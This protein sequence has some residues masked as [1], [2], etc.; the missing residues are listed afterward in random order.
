[1]K[2]IIID[3][4]VM[5]LLR[6]EDTIFR[7]GNISTFPVETAEELLE[8]HGVH[9]G[10]LIIAQESIQVMGGEGLCAS[11]RKDTDLKNVSILIVTDGLEDCA[12]RWHAA[13]ANAVVPKS[14]DRAQL[15][16][17]I[18]ELLVIPERK[19]LRVQLSAS[20]RNEREE[21]TFLAETRNISISGILLET[22]H[23][24]Q[25]GDRLQCS[26]N[27]AHSKINVQCRVARVPERNPD[28][29]L[30]GLTFVNPDMK[31]LIIIENYVKMQSRRQPS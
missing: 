3:R 25:E 29:S 28:G 6:C 17:K 26:F 18:S 30:Y 10:D 5:K 14:F 13:G 23:I 7:R 31:T 1:M 24:L 22:S 20:V 16:F 27:I 12:A 11:L 2:K 19:D 21:E 9:R 4:S 15:F 8:L